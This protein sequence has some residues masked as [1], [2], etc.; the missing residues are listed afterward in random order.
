MCLLSQ[1]ARPPLPSSSPMRCLPDQKR[2]RLRA[3]GCRRPPSRG[4]GVQTATIRH[5]REVRQRPPISRATW[6]R[7]RSKGRS[8]RHAADMPNVPLASCFVP[9]GPARRRTAAV[10]QAAT[11]RPAGLCGHQG[12]GSPEQLC[13]YLAGAPAA[14]ASRQPALW[15]LV[16]DPAVGLLIAGVALKEG[17]EAWRGEGAASATRSRAPSL[18]RA[19]VGTAA[20]TG[21][22]WRSGGLPLGPPGAQVLGP[23]RAAPRVAT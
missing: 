1:A 9:D 21:E 18:T 6:L 2:R 11:G 19:A 10:A 13:A 7:R 20:A 14:G 22:R 16:V 12:R 4:R 17:L 23:A 15:R 5:W 8:V 3:Y